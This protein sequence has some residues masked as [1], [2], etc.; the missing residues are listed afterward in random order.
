MTVDDNNRAHFGCRSIKGSFDI[1]YYLRGAREEVGPRR[2]RGREEEQ[3]DMLQGE[4]R[5]INQH[6]AQRSCMW[7][8]CRMRRWLGRWMLWGN[9]DGGGKLF[10]G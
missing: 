2:R 9:L 4:V 1:A 5:R 3:Q 6:L 10:G 8:C 7:A